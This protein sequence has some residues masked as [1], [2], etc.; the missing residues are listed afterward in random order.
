[1][2]FF[3]QHTVFLKELFQKQKNNLQILAD[4]SRSNP[5]LQQAI[6]QKCLPSYHKENLE[7]RI[8]AISIQRTTKAF[9]EITGS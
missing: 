3:S 9:R 8:C 5:G 7:N 4:R 6:I 1:M 2:T